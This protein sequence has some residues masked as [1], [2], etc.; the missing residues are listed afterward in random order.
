MGKGSLLNCRIH[1]S[2]RRCYICTGDQFKAS[3]LSLLCE[4][5]P[6]QACIV[7][8]VYHNNHQLYNLR[9]EELEPAVITA[10]CYKLNGSINAF[11]TWLQI[12][13]G[14][15]IEN[16]DGIMKK[17][18]IC[19]QNIVR[20][21]WYPKWYWLGKK[22]H[23][24]FS[25]TAISILSYIYLFY[26]FYTTLLLRMV[27]NYFWPQK[28]PSD[29]GWFHRLLAI[30]YPLTRRRR[31]LKFFPRQKSKIWFMSCKTVH[32]GHPG[33]SGLLWARFPQQ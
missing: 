15:C 28:Q 18:F 21:A 9:S 32:N 11:S 14:A 24:L 10:A 12:S 19:Q 31:T 1:S 22:V 2:Q 6:Q 27:Y 5:G 13:L 33:T 20:A 30:C 17:M 23:V 26:T 25:H 8:A 3:Y 4:N 29:I 16:A 7:P